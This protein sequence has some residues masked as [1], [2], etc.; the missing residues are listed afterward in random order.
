LLGG[1]EARRAY[2]E[3]ETS[4]KRKRS[5]VGA[6]TEKKVAHEK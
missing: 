5:R 1:I 3:V 2:A 4:K 6:K